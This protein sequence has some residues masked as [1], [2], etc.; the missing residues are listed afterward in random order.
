M[1]VATLYQISGTTFSNKRKKRGKST[2]KKREIESNE[3]RDKVTER[4]TEGKRERQRYREK[5]RVTDRK[6]E[7]E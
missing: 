5:D 6:T 2:L 1:S 4:K 7:T 3:E